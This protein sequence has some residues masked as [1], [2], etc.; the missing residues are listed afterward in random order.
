VKLLKKELKIKNR[1]NSKN[2]EDDFKD[3]NK[4]MDEWLEP[5]PLPISKKKFIT[6]IEKYTLIVYLLTACLINFI[7]ETISR[8]SFVEAYNYFSNSKDVFLY[9]SFII[10]VTLTLSYLVRNR[11]FTSMVI[12]GIWVI[13]GVANGVVLS[14]RTTPFTGTDLKFIKYAAEITTKYVSIDQMILAALL[15]IAFICAFIYL[16]RRGP[17]FKGKMRYKR[18][19]T[20]IILLF[21]SIL[22]ITK[23]C[24]NE[25][26][27][28]TYFGNITIAYEDYGF[29]YCFWCT[30]LAKG[31]D[32]PNNYGE[33]KVR[34]I[35]N[36]DGEDSYN[37]EKTPNI[38]I[39]QLESFFDPKLIKDLKFSEDPIPNFKKLQQNYSS[40]YVTVPV[41]GAGTV[42]TEFEVLTG[43][44]LRYFG[45]GEYPYK[46]VLLDNVCESIAYDLKNIG[47]STHAIH[48]NVAS[49][50]GRDTV[51]SMLGFDTFTPQENMNITEYTPLGWAKDAILKDTIMDT[52]D[53]TEEKDFVYTITVQ[54]HGGY[55]SEQILENP[56]ITVSGANDDV[57]NSTI[58]YYV[59]QINEVDQFIGNL[60]DELSNREEDTVLVL[61]GDH[62]PSL[63]LE[64]DDL[65]NGSIFQTEYVIWDNM[66]LKTKDNN[67][68]A[69]Q[70]ASIAL[71][72]IDMNV[73]TLMKFHQERKG[74]KNYYSDLETLQYDMLYGKKYV[75]GGLDK[76][77]KV[78]M[79]MGIKDI[80]APS[81][82]F[83]LPS[84]VTIK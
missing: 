46:T 15:V 35:V 7:I 70:L 49:F 74:T 77:V 75:Y 84:S 59:N 48:N 32:C 66:D 16:G 69:Y 9:N 41:V 52:L 76:Y 47:Y 12:S 26:I 79:Q 2:S 37:K 30:V 20:F 13:G 33:S 82:S 6:I 18:N 22:P 81:A 62:L 14:F 1:K 55:P 25:K 50:Y 72:K 43:M 67:I 54:S 40:G 17:R 57:N 60:V 71:D 29:P 4:E 53:S 8:H 80:V 42:N 27:L 78:D 51:F 36:R 65:Y 28:S 21:I 61:F 23:W 44:S 31:I 19:I 3:D 68:K 38:I 45:P 63:G 73:G 5:N 83:G 10:F 64:A 34:S 11:L 56:K 24:V 58:E 39:V